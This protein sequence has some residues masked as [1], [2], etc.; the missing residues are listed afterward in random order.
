MQ[1]KFANATSALRKEGLHKEVKKAKDE[2]YIF[3]KQ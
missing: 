1:S 2:K 3:C